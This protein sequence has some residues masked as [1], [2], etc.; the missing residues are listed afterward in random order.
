MDSP[1]ILRK[2]D[3]ASRIKID[4]EPGNVGESAIPLHGSAP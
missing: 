4:D 1:V 2:N 3:F